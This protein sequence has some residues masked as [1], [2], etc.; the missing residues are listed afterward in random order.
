V[1]AD[2]DTSARWSS[3]TTFIAIVTR[4]DIAM[5]RT[6][7]E[8]P[9]VLGHGPGQGAERIRRA[10]LEVVPGSADG[11]TTR[12]R[13]GSERRCR[14]RRT[15]TDA[16]AQ[17]HP[18]RGRAP[19][20]TAK[21]AADA[22]WPDGAGWTQ[23]SA[24]SGPQGRQAVAARGV[25]GRRRY[26][27]AQFTINEVTRSPRPVAPNPAPAR[28]A[29]ERK[30]RCCGE[31]WLGEVRKVG[32]HASGSSHGVDI[33]PRPGTQPGRLDRAGAVARPP[34]TSRGA[35]RR[36][37]TVGLRPVPTRWVVIIPSLRQ[38]T[39]VWVRRNQGQPW[40]VASNE[41]LRLPAAGYVIG[42]QTSGA[43]TVEPRRATG[44]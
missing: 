8:P 41:A 32:H 21:A 14:R 10:T 4:F 19:T 2:G 5:T 11:H 36:S 34:P 17:R 27:W 18:Q 39:T 28:T 30:D 12:R 29:D 43:T 20:E 40:Y 15:T 22:E 33:R 25:G 35:A 1:G 6:A 16:F 23:A 3:S 26:S 42:G 44:A 38:L 37:S 9:H 31:L 24:P 7:R 13:R